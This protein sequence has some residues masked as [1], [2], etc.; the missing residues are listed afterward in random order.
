MYIMHLGIIY[1]T[2]FHLKRNASLRDNLHTYLKTTEISDIL[3][4]DIITLR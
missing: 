4:N 3:I 2:R 1:L